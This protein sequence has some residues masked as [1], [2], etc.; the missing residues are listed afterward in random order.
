MIRTVSYRRPPAGTDDRRKRFGVVCARG[1]AHVWVCSCVG[2]LVRVLVH[3]LCARACVCA[4][5]IMP[6]WLPYVG[7]IVHMGFHGAWTMITRIGLESATTDYD[8]RPMKATREA[9]NR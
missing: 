6:S 7:A 8:N 1:C 9:Y 2:V 3:V 4:L 5:Q